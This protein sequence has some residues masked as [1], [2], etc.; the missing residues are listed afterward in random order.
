M[1]YLDHA[2]T[3]AMRPV[4][5]DTWLAAAEVCGNAS[6]VHQGGRAARRILEDAREQV[7]ADLAVPAPWVVF[8]SGG[9]EA[10][11]Q[12][13]VGTYFARHDEDPRRRRILV[14]RMEHKA[15]LEP[16][17]HLEPADAELGWLDVDRAGR[18][19]PGQVA[20]I[21]A[22]DG[23][24]VALVAVMWA[25]N[26]VGTVQPIAELAAICRTAGVPL[27]TDAVQALGN[28]AVDG[29][30]ATT[31]ALSAHKVGGPTGVG[32]LVVDPVAA[33][34]P[35]LR[36]GGQESGARA[37]TANVAGAAAAAAAIHEAVTA[38]AE[39]AVRVRALRDQ[40]LSGIAD[41]AAAE[42]FEYVVNGD[43]EGGLPG[44]ASV[45][46]VDCDGDALMM[47]MDGA[48]VA[49]STGS[50]CSVGIPKP[51]HVL[52]A[53]GAPHPAGTLR[54][55]LGWNSTADDI[56]AALAA[57]PRAVERARRAS[58]VGGGRSR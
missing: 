3:T 10:D 24:D 30:A 45:S 32:V 42:G 41:S 4:A 31:T 1:P 36:G 49:V 35:L 52:A 51:S 46:F 14:S 37:G 8:T 9:T 28:I 54:F 33:L 7:A 13:V 26:E 27:H 22:R 21:L 20:E 56:A 25:N 50:A 17:Q 19:D 39:H 48:G 23:D 53:M 18:V 38:T 47:L 44:L 12:A 58:A 6:S 5:R 43:D 40:L 11:N 16:A 57:L 15:V 29:A 2:A 34:R 55:S